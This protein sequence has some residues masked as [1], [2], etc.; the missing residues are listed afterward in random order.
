MS[1]PSIIKLYLVLNPAFFN[2]ILLVMKI[3]L[4]NPF[5]FKIFISNYYELNLLE[6]KSNDFDL[7]VSNYLNRSLLHVLKL[8]I[9]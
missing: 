4:I 9:L 8:L 2:V 5:D 7:H 3:L 6:K 1:E